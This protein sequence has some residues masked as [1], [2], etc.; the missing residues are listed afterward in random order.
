[1]E[2]EALEGFVIELGAAGEIGM[3]ISLAMMMFAVALGLR[4]EHFAFFKTQPRHYLAGLT[5]QILALPLLTLALVHLLNPAP[6]LAL[7]MI[8]VACCP[9]GN[10]SNLLA[11]FGR[12]NTALS[13]SMTASSSLMAAFITPVSIVFWSSLYG[14]T[15]DL[16]GQIDFNIVSFLLQTLLI[17]GLPIA[18][19]MLVVRFAPKLAARLQKPLALISGGALL[20]II[21]GGV[22]TYHDLLLSAGALIIPLVI[23]HNGCAL[24]LGYGTGLLTRADIATRRALT[25]E[26]G[27]QNSGLGLMILLTQMQGFGGAFAIIGAWGIWH[28]IAGTAMVAAFRLADKKTK[29]ATH[30]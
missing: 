19:G 15:R 5:A 9:G 11:L 17:L 28:I 21:A 12:A 25:F 7:G 18:L 10:V 4:A 1:M 22:Y 8:L 23:I 24:A 16:L 3:A 14:P 13:V 29:R 2:P 20:L 30:V 6:S 26:V 27:I